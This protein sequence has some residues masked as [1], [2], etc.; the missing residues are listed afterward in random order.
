MTKLIQSSNLPTI[1]PKKIFSGHLDTGSAPTGSAKKNN[2]T[3]DLDS[4]VNFA[5]KPVNSGISKGS[6]DLYKLRDE[7]AKVLPYL[8]V[9]KCGKVPYKKYVTIDKNE[10]NVKRYGNINHCG[11]VWICP[12]CA[13]KKMKVRQEQIKEII[14]LHNN[15]GCSFYF[16][17]LTIRH[18][19][20]QPLTVLLKNVTSAWRK[21]T[22]ERSIK[23]L[24][25]TAN[26][27]QS[28][29]C[30]FSFKT[31]WSPHFHAVFMS[32]EK[33]KVKPLF[34]LLIDS[35][36][37][38]TGSE[39]KG[40]KIIE[41]TDEE[42][43]SEYIAKISLANELTE[44]Q[45]K[46]SKKGNSFSYFDMLKDT[47]KFRKQIEEYGYATKG[48]QTLRKSRGLNITND[49][50]NDKDTVK[51]NLLNIHEIAYKQTIV[52]KCDYKKVLEISDKWPEIVEYFKGY[53]INQSEKMISPKGEINKTS[54]KIR[55]GKKPQFY[56]KLFDKMT[57]KIFIGRPAKRK[58]PVNF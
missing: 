19:D 41:A 1:W 42:S 5:A 6:F 13:Y 58:K 29:E 47:V 52:K 35:W 27:I 17:T 56:R 2:K 45:T 21:I 40:Q 14:K 12:T 51:E 48:V 49:K 32:T 39:K 22:E 15:S 50:D 43:L 38:K 30:R 10:K 3:F 7:A 16:I 9:C 8:G 34:D 31:G 23:P 33:E 28:L 55:T 53:N 57:G 46:T 24:F 20:N 26:Y 11:S 44:G 36:I 37:K 25:K 4:N 54:P 18:Q